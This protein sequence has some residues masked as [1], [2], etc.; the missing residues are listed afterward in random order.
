MCVCQ[1]CVYAVARHTYTY[2]DTSSRSRARRRRSN[3]SSSLAATT[4]CSCCSN[5]VSLALSRAFI[6]ADV[7]ICCF[8]WMRIPMSHMGWLP[9][10]G[11]LKLYV[12]FA[13]ETYTRDDI[14]QKRP[15]ILRS[16]LTAA[17][18]YCGCALA[19]YNCKCNICMYTSLLQKS[20]IK[21][22]IFCKRDL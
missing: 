3:C 16:L 20:A 18:P 21:E 8:W 10:V 14:L 12:S 19:F 17:T 22:T 15:I 9:L 5:A 11:S 2:R 13:K 7:F 4:A 1:V 6:H